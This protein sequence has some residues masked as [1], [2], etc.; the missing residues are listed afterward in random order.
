MTISVTQPSILVK[1]ESA[2][3]DPVRELFDRDLQIINELG[4]ELLYAIESHPHAGHV[5]SSGKLRQNTGAKIVFGAKL[6]SIFNC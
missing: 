1:Q 3:I 4:I 6:R 2:I 5:T